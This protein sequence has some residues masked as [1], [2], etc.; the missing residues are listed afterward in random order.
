MKDP[1]VP[2]RGGRRCAGWEGIDPLLEHRRRRGCREGRGRVRGHRLQGA[3]G[4]PFPGE[5][6]PRQNQ[7]GRGGRV[8]NQPP[9]RSGKRDRSPTSTSSRARTA[10]IRRVIEPRSGKMPTTSVRRRVP[11]FSRSLGLL[12]E[13]WRQISCGKGGERQDVGAGALEQ[14]GGRRELA[15]SRLDD[16]GELGVH[17]VGIGLVEDR[18]QQR[19]DPR[20][21]SS[22]GSPT[23]GSRRSG[24]GT[25]AWGGLAPDVSGHDRA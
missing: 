19:L 14:L 18:V 5:R 4:P 1:V 8:G 22:S 13:I 21:G 10:P 25:V 16:A 23:S 11:R 15:R 9:V 2:V 3:P 17:R 6:H 24:C 7:H 12:D 20:P